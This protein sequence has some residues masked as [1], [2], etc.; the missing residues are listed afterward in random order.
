MN[1]LNTRANRSAIKVQNEDELITA[2]F[3]V[4]TYGE[5]LERMLGSHLLN[6][7]FASYEVM[8]EMYKDLELVK[9]LA[10]LSFTQL[11]GEQK[12]VGY[13]KHEHGAVL[14]RHKGLDIP[15]VSRGRSWYCADAHIPKIIDWMLSIDTPV[16]NELTHSLDSISWTD[17]T[18]FL[19]KDIEFFIANRPWFEKRQL[20]YTRSYLFHGPPG[21]GKSST[22]RALKD[23]LKCKIAKFDFTASS[24]APDTAF[25]D[26]ARETAKVEGNKKQILST[27]LVFEDLDRF[28][29]KDKEPATRVSLST[30]LNV[31]DGDDR[32][33]NAIIVATANNPE[34]LDQTVIL[35]PGRFDLRVRF[36]GPT[37]VQATSYLKRFLT[38]DAVADSTLW[39]IAEMCS[40]HSHAFLRGVFLSA[41][42]IASQRKA[43][44]MIRDED[45]LTSAKTHLTNA[46][47]VKHVTKNKTGF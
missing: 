13:A 24:D 20:P 17:E 15:I 30:L 23:T 27:I 2:D 29:P 28:F 31:F 22:I 8:T 33:D 10:S 12:L 34:D 4:A 16:K 37:K 32:P 7:W 39:E 36:D 26:W 47:N 41:G 46:M 43:G 5:D 3:F 19:R 44:D 11:E 18:S 14:W 38:E 35:R 40:G 1:L 42:T 21:N 6:A 45:M 9:H 25:R